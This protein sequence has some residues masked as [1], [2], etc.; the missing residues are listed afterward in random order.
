MLAQASWAQQG[1]PGAAPA[2]VLSS[3][4]PSS[5][6]RTGPLHAGPWITHG[7]SPP[8]RLRFTAKCPGPCGPEPH[9]P[10]RGLALRPTQSFPCHPR[11]GRDS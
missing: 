3:G 1:L 2:L 6:P 10:S 4:P 9:T 11:V 8:H 5:Q 7:A